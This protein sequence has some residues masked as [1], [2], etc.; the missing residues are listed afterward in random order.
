ML[1]TLKIRSYTQ[2]E[3]KYSALVSL[4]APL[5]FILIFLAP[6]LILSKRPEKLNVVILMIAYV[7]IVL[8]SAALFFIYNLLLV[9]FV[10]V[11][12]FFHK[13][14]MIFVYSKH[15][16]VS[17]AMKFFYGFLYTAYGI[18]SAFVNAFKDTGYFMMHCFVMT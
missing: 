6:F 13:L 11:K 18:P 14:T 7:P 4:P 5:N 17:R 1:E 8:I 15:I 3:S 9:P 16:R 2:V 10:F 12:M